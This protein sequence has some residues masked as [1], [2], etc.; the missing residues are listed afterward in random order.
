MTLIDQFLK[1]SWV[2]YILAFVGFVVGLAKFL[3]AAKKIIGYVVNLR[4]VLRG[5]KLSD[6]QLGKEA[7]NLVEK[8]ITLVSERQ[9]TE[10]QIDFDNFH[11]S[12]NHMIKHSQETQNQYAKDYASKVV[13]IR[14][15]FLK[16]KLKNE[17]VERFYEHPTNYLGLRALAVGIGSLAESIKKT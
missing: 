12:S 9:N 8:I 10:P 16:R 4:N 13:H 14:N 7:Q 2:L 15:E 3:D 5:Q 11:E 17:D 1:E 6:E